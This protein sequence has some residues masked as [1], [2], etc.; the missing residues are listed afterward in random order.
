MLDHR[1]ARVFLP[2]L[3]A[4]VAVSDAFAPAGAGESRDDRRIRALLKAARVVGIDD[5]APRET[6][7]IELAGIKRGGPFL[8]VH[9]VRAHRVAPVHVAP[10]RAVGVVL[11][12]EVIRTRV[13][14]QPVGVIVPAAAGREVELGR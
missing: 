1:V 14:D 4:V 9:Q 11:V 8:P 6:P 13:P 3:A 2:G 5:R 7:V 12:E 10:V